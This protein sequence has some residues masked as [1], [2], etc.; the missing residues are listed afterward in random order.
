MD[1]EERANYEGEIYELKEE[2]SKYEMQ[3]MQTMF[4]IHDP[5]KELK[6]IADILER[7]LKLSEM[8]L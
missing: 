6:R 8:N 7:L 4:R 2:L 1:D 3:P 5:T